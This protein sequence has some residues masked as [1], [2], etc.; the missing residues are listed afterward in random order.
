MPYGKAFQSCNATT[1][2]AREV[3]GDCIRDT[4]SKRSSADRNDLVGK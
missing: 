4:T 2:K 1:Q 3:E